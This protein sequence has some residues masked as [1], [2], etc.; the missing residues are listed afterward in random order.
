RFRQDRLDDA[1]T[2]LKQ[3]IAILPDQYPAHVNLALVH[4]RQ[5]KG[6]DADRAF[7]R[8]IRLVPRSAADYRD[9]ARLHK[10]RGNTAS[11][12]AD[13]EKAIELG[14]PGLGEDHAERGRL[15]HR[16][17]SYPEAVKAYDQALRIAPH[18]VA[19]HRWRAEA[20]VEV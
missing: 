10:D 17:K 16:A 5:K 13:C 14:P 2:D 18:H 20:L 19:V 9:R 15:L 3:A 7:A 12:L 1:V 4:H 8:V 6:Q 11:A